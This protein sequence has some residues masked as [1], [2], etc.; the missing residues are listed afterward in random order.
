MELIV[1]EY[2]VSPNVA[3]RNEFSIRLVNDEL[4]INGKKIEDEKKVFSVK[5]VLE[6]NKEEIIT[7]AAKR[8]SNYKGGRQKY[9]TVKY[10]DDG[11][12]YMI[13]GNN[14]LNEVADFYTRIVNEI[15]NIIKR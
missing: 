2:N 12:K 4:T 13:V 15:A 9:L 1:Y 7:L 3:A 6:E 14:S 11:E 8:A 10:E 5:K